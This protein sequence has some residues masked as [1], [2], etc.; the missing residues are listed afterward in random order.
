MKMAMFAFFTF[1]RFVRM[2]KPARLVAW[3]NTVA[4]WI[5][6]ILNERGVCRYHSGY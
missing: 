6:L 3:C 1:L 4:F 5:M 2:V